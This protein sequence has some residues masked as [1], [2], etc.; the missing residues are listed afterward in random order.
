MSE[1]ENNKPSPAAPARKSR[2]K[3]VLG[4]AALIALILFSVGLFNTRTD[5]EKAEA[6]PGL[7][8]PEG[9]QLAEVKREAVAPL[10][11]VIGTLASEVRVNLRA[12]IP[13]EIKEI[14][15]SAGSPV[16][17]DQV[18]I[19][20]DDREIREQATAAE[21]ESKQAEAEY[22]RTRQ[23]FDNKAATQQALTA[24]ESMFTAARAQWERS[25]VML[26]YARIT[27]PMDGVVTDRRAEPGDLANPG[28]ALLAIYDASR[29]QLEAPVPV[30]LLDKLPIG[31]EV[32]VTLDNATNT[33]RGVVGS[34][35]SEIDPLS[36]TQLIKVRIAPAP[37][38]LIPGAFGRLWV[39]DNPREAVLV[40]ASAVYRV[41]Q[42]EF[43]QVARESRALRRAVRTVPGPEGLA[44]AL[45][46][47]EAGEMVLA[48]PLKEN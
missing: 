19:L 10:I 17:K 2:V 12:R 13:A 47:L 24:A 39:K 33:L 46:G 5:L 15:V 36:R 4:L 8:I 27:A 11:G 30:R 35:V 1:A 21:A 32:E 43:V 34:I 31:R 25:K 37:A 29:M 41:G 22:N 45:A 23:L 44:E 40:P 3:P 14:S 48:N 38:G 20:L 26:T 18:L 7:P 42:L 9:A 28:Q 6:K 16:K